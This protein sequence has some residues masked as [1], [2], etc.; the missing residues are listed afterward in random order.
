ML[1][2]RIKFLCALLAAV[3]ILTSLGTPAAADGGEISVSAKAA[4]L[5]TADNSTVLYEKASEEKLPMAST[6]KIMTALLTL[7]AAQAEDR[8]VKIT[9]EMVRVE[10]SSMGLKPG[11]VVTLTALA[12]GM[13]LCSG[14]DAANAAAIAIAGS[15]EEFSKLMNQRAKQIGMKNTSFVTPS[16][17]DDENH[18]TTAYDMALL[19]ACAME[20]QKFRE[21]ASQKSMQVQFIE[22]DLKYTFGNHNQ[23]LTAY[24]GCIGVKTGFTKKSGRCLVSCAERDGVRLMAVTLN[25]PDDWND[26]KAMLDYGF[27]KVKQVSFDDTALGLQVPAV[28]GVRDS[29]TVNAAFTANA[30][31]LA[32]EESKITKKFEIAGF[33]YAP[34]RKG[35][36]VGKLTYEIDGRVLASVDLL[37][38][39]D[40]PAQIKQ[41]SLWERFL[42]WFR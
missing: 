30:S 12:Q 41:K 31:V 37:A 40:L 4:V 33:L 39:E 18:Y 19:G 1:K 8:Q 26:H 10:G 16:G 17:L 13:L 7:E 29:I 22:P 5:M 24:E 11:N 25:A 6:T 27:S 28:G 34:V 14:N 32:E 35:Q 21:I 15:P 23:L 20:N 36:T 2:K 42:D 3:G 38:G 9:D